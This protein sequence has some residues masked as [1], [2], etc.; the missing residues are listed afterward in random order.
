MPPSGEV[1]CAD[2]VR[3]RSV[4]GA[5][6]LRR[7]LEGSDQ[8]RRT[9]VHRRVQL[10]LLDLPRLRPV[11]AQG[12]LAHSVEAPL[13]HGRHDFSYGFLHRAVRFR[14]PAAKARKE[15]IFRFSRLPG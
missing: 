12:V 5:D 15:R 3:S 9:G 4:I 1:H 2:F 8:L 10:L 6:V 14:R 11:K 13:L 7:P